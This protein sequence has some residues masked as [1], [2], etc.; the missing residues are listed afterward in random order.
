MERVLTDIN[1]DYS[2]SSAEVLRHGV[3]LVVGAPSAS[4][5]G[6][7][8]ARPD[9]SISGLS[10]GFL[11]SWSI[12]FDNEINKQ[13][14]PRGERMERRLAAI[15]AAERGQQL[16]RLSESATNAVPDGDESSRYRGAISCRCYNL[17]NDDWN[18]NTDGP[19]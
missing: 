18:I 16:W 6:R 3:L 17:R 19:G 13:V 2:D 8:G 12:W 10:V 11:P 14:L 9:H 7:A 15:L 1:A 4:I 5:A